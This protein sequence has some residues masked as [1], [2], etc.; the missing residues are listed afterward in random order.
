MDFSQYVTLTV[1]S[2]VISTSVSYNQL[3]TLSI[4]VGYNTNLEGLP[5][6]MTLSYDPLKVALP[7]TTLSFNM[8][9]SNLP[10]II[11]DISGQEQI[12][13]Y[14]GFGLAGLF[15]LCLILS[16]VFHKMIGL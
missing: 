1:G 3:G 9:G 11:A 10:V 8:V 13:Y 14:I 6:Q 15:L 12:V 4:V 2:E 5:T 16:T 7:T